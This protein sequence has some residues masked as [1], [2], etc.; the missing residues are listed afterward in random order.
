MPFMR[1]FHNLKLCPTESFE[2][3]QAQAGAFITDFRPTLQVR[4]WAGVAGNKM[5]YIYI[6]I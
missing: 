6:Y 5:V 4:S 2:T 1:G 3:P